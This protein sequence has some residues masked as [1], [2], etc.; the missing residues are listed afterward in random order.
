M[1][2]MNTCRPGS[3]QGPCSGYHPGPHRRVRR[4]P[5][6]RDPRDD[7]PGR[8]AALRV[9]P[10]RRNRRPGHVR[11]V[12]AHPEGETRLGADERGLHQ[13]TPGPLQSV[14]G[15]GQPGRPAP[16][17]RDR[18]RR[19]VPQQSGPVRGDVLGRLHHGRGGLSGV[20]S[21]AGAAEAASGVSDQDG[22]V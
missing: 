10:A 7:P 11:L 19:L 18:A 9:R 8:A 4:R 2:L 6:R 14:R 12:L 21:G 1:I 17:L 16:P 5:L 3:R 15:P 22:E 13:E 20:R